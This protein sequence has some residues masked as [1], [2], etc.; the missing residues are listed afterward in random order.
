MTESNNAQ[1]HTTR[2][3]NIN[4]RTKRLV[5]EIDADRN[6]LKVEFEEVAKAKI[7]D[8]RAGG[9]S[10]GLM[11]ARI[12]LADLAKVELE[13]G[14]MGPMVQV[15]TDNP[16]H[17]CLASQYAGWQISV[18][19]YF[20]M[21]S[22]PMRAVAA[23]E[24]IFK[25]IPG[26]EE[27]NCAVGVLETKKKPTEQVVEYLFS[28]LPNVNDLTLLYAPAASLA[29]SIQ[30]V[31]RS[32]ETALH[33]LHELKFD[34][35]K[36]VSGFG[37]APLPSIAKDE[38]AAIGRTNDSILYGAKVTLWVNADD[39]E[40]LNIGPKVP[41]NSSPDYGELFADLFKRYG[42]FYKIDPMLF[43]PAMITFVNIATGKQF[44]FGQ[45]NEGLLKKS[46]Q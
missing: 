26:K 36:I 28:K 46:F 20:A 30:V 14:D 29:G 9:L 27:S 17:A 41:S 19:K 43:S 13:S 21:G 22:G 8:C 33:K 18:D 40:L 2:Q 34:V 15:W 38:L 12:C 1:L 45:L 42:D 4:S 25:H 44:T 23:R 7:I 3:L 6:R 31:A 5:D 32:V 37:I 10:T 35:T 39:E 24:E 11:L 16:V